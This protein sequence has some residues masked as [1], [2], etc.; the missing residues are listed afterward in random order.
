[1]SGRC[2]CQTVVTCTR[3][4]KPQLDPSKLALGTVTVHPKARAR[5]ETRPLCK[6]S[7]ATALPWQS[8]VV[9]CM[10]VRT[11][12]P[13]VKLIFASIREESQRAAN[14]TRQ[15]VANK[16]GIVRRLDS[17]YAKGRVVKNKVKLRDVKAKA[18]SLNLLAMLHSTNG[19]Q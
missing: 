7:V 13:H 15:A 6:G 4:K 11:R 5:V 14:K 12:E 17:Q 8:V 2:S 1:M 10:L 18:G 19:S 16:H 3:L 9:L